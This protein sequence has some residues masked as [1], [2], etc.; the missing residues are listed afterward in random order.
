MTGAYANVPPTRECCLGLPLEQA[1]TLCRR[2]GWTP[3]I[4]YTGERAADTQYTPRVIALR[5]NALVVALFRDQT[6]LAA[7]DVEQV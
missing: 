7:A 1:L 6:P 2:M 5:E 4:M 3:E